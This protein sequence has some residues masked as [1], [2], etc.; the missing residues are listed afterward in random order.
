M[1]RWMAAATAGLA[2]VFGLAA[3]GAAKASSSNWYQVYQSGYSG[4]FFDIAAISKSDAWAVGELENSKG[5]TIYE[6]FIRH[7]NGSGWLTVTIPGAK[8]VTSDYVAASS[9]SN[10]WIAGSTSNFTGS[11]VYRYDGSHWHK[12]A[13]PAL[14]SVLGLVV[15]APNNVWAIGS[16]GTVSGNV[17]HWNGSRWV[18][19]DFNV[20]PQSI[21]ASSA[22]N[23]WMA[24]IGYSG[25]TQLAVA[26]Q[27]NGRTW[28]NAH[29]ARTVL[30]AGPAVSA[31]SP[32]D[33]WVGW[34]TETSADALHWD[35]HHWHVVKAADDVAADSSDIITDGQGGWWWGP[36]ARLDGSTWTG[37]AIPEA[38]AGGWGPVVR[39]P[40]TRSFWLAATVKNHGD[41]T[42]HPTIYR[43]DL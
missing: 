37:V 26:Y 14:A 3:P 25:K 18:G 2:A 17:F 29:L 6:P 22:D 36:F 40:G 13:L 41:S 23:V 24:G 10:V 34:S 39:I 33:V 35:G 27:W 42:Q 8:N 28:H 9:A 20:L 21:S 7:Y 16:L 1:K 31:V 30:L 19:Y 12:V 5:D 15:L 43:F 11:E 4:A 32:S 38:S